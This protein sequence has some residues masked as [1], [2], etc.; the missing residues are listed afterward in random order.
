MSK[1]GVPISG[2]VTGLGV[3]LGAFSAATFAFG[4][5]FAL[6]AYRGGSNPLTIV[7][8]RITVFVLVVG[9]SRVFA[10]RVMRLSRPALLATGWMAGTLAMVSLGYQGSV[11]FIPVNLAALI[12]YT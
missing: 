5:T 1:A 6:L 7:L 3:A 2:E 12:F 8:V 4:T 10:G 9:A 11:A